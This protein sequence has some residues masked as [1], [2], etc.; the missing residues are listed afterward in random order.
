MELELRPLRMQM[1]E[2]EMEL[3][4]TE[5][6]RRAI[7]EAGYDPE[8]GARPL[9]RVIQNQIQDPLSEGM[10]AEKFVPGDTITVDYREVVGEDGVAT[11]QF[12][13][14]VTAHKDVTKS[15]EETDEFE[16]LLQ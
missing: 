2:H 15:S 16:A 11:H 13:F 8:Y 5:A 12:V 7:A 6:A 14:E 4:L 3:I 10:L 1:A 9:R